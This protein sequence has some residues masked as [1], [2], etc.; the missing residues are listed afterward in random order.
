MAQLVKNL[1]AV[2]ET[3]VGKIPWRRERLPT[4]VFWPGEFHGLYSPSGRKELD[5]TEW[6]SLSLSDY[7][8]HISDFTISNLNHIYKFPFACSGS[9]GEKKSTC[10]A[11]DQ[12]SIPGSGSSP[13]EGNGTPLQDSGLENSLSCGAW[14][15]TVHG[16]QRV[17]QDWATNTRFHTHNRFA[18]FKDCVYKP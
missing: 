11:G 12:G 13:R 2:W 5:T 9:E 10:N 18:C 14:Q 1:P 4:P 17:R 7:P 6:L 3:W 8:G 15:A 16:W